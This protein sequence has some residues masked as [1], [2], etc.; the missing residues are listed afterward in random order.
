MEI[1]FEAREPQKA[2]LVFLHGFAMCAEDMA[3]DLAPVAA[4]LPWLRI[5]VPEAP[6]VPV[7]A[8]GGD[9]YRSW[10]DYLT[11]R[12]GDAEDVV[13]A[14]TVRAARNNIQRIVWREHN[15]ARK[16]AFP[17]KVIIGGLSQGGCLALDL[18]TREKQLTGVVTAVAHRLYLSRSRPLLCSWHALFAEEDDVFPLTWAAPRSTD[19][20]LLTVSEGSDHYLAKGE[21]TPFI[22]KAVQRAVET[23][24]PATQQGDDIITNVSTEDALR[25]A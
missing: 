14:S 18:A 12:E 21:L 13:D 7:T 1:V 15:Y 3:V 24:L 5:V 25:T 2:T 20:V 6:A 19:N 8:Y 16:H 10:F 22:V 17:A 23:A 9:E 11:D 4:Q